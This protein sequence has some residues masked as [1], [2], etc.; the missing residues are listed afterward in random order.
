M[1]LHGQQ[2]YPD[3]QTL[4]EKIEMETGE[5]ELEWEWELFFEKRDAMHDDKVFQSMLESLSST[6]Y[7]YECLGGDVG[8]KWSAFVID[9]NNK[10]LYKISRNRIE[11]IEI[12]CDM[13][14]CL[15]CNTK[16]NN[17]FIEGEITR[18]YSVSLITLVNNSV[19]SWLMTG[20]SFGP[21]FRIDDIA[22]S[23][24]LRLRRTLVS[25]FDKIM[26]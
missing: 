20:G 11:R 18:G 5:K 3:N 16:F 21:K 9:I 6:Y 23:D 15:N 10:A 14:D 17:S 8:L 13:S 4:I 22:K 12:K 26:P 24:D 2:Y 7:I 1:K 25:I 19:T